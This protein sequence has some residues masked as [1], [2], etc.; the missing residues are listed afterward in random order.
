MAGNAAGLKR[1]AGLSIFI[2]L[3]LAL[4]GCEYFQQSVGDDRSAADHNT[5]GE[6]AASERP[7]EADSQKSATAAESVKPD[8]TVREVQ[9]LLA[10]LG[11]DPGPADG[12]LGHRT[13]DAIRQYQK[14]AG[15]AVDGKIGELLVVK[16]K[17]GELMRS[18]AAAAQTTAGGAT[19]ATPALTLPVNGI[20]VAEF[21]DIQPIYTPGD[22]FVWSSGYVDRVVRVGADNVVWRSTDGT[23]RTAFRYFATPYL[24]WQNESIEAFSTMGI[25]PQDVWPLAPGADIEFKVTRTVR[26][27][28]D[29]AAKESLEAWHCSRGADAV[30]AVPAGRFE[31]IAVTCL[32]TPA[33]A[34]GW[35]KRVWYYAPAVRHFVRLDSFEGDGRP[36]SKRL[37]SLRPAWK[38][39]PPAARAGLDWAVQDTLS[40]GVEGAGVEW[41]S[42]GVG[43]KL[44]IL[45]GKEFEARD[46]R[47]CRKYALIQVPPMAPRVYPAIACWDPVREKWLVPGLDDN[48]A[49]IATVS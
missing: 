18:G 26:K 16:L 30:V 33:P 17:S 23:G 8:E 9:T 3:M 40:T 2:M 31:T 27:L 42:S 36:F 24:E 49:P 32:R 13:T 12:V 47:R 43:T 7:D 39:W 15:L 37:V 22:A 28:G 20:F 38:D 35:R 19:G 4:G 29:Q 6:D 11:Y 46:D 45:P 34:S 5:A 1:G 21:G 48:S 10:G 44:I 14:A 25:D 41:R